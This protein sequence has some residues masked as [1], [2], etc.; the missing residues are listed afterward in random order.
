MIEEGMVVKV[1]PFDYGHRALFQ[2]KKFK[3]R[4]ADR[5]L[6]VKVARVLIK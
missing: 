3:V 6:H 5:T 2:T 1:L 4:T